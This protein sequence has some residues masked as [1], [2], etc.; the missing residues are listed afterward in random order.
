ME[1]YFLPV[2]GKN[3][4]KISKKGINL[5]IRLEF[6]HQIGYNLTAEKILDRLRARSEQN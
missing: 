5:K 1:K 3:F 2:F 4:G 6:Y